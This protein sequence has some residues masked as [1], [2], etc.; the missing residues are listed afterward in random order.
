M[1]WKLCKSPGG[2]PGL[3]VPFSP[4]SLCGRKATLNFTSRQRGRKKKKRKER[5]KSKKKDEDIIN[6]IIK[7][8]VQRKIFFREKILQTR[9]TVSVGHINILPST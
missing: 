2:R 5:K 7:S 9:V 8:I 4:Y 3:P 6:I 1:L